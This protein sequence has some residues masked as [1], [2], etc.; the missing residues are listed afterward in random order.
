MW[1]RRTK[2]VAASVGILLAVV[3]FALVILWRDR[4]DLDSVNWRA[5]PEPV[6]GELSATWLVPPSQHF[7]PFDGCRRFAAQPT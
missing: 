6:D 1:R 3:V 2:Q 7:K 4:P 5:G